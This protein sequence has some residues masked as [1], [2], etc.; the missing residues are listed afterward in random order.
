MDI[1]DL[2]YELIDGLG[3]VGHLFGFTKPIFMQ[4]TKQTDYLTDCL[5][6][7][8]W[9]LGDIGFEVAVQPHFAVVFLPLL[10]R[11]SLDPYHFWA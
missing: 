1:M 2:L 6:L 4:I 9:E 11:I 7:L 3:G 10:T 5:V 8:D